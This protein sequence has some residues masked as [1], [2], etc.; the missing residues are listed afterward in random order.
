LDS[1][2]VVNVLTTVPLNLFTAGALSAFY[3][4]NEFKPDI[5]INAGTAGGFKRAG[6]A[7]GDAFI[8]TRCAHHDR[9]IPIP[10][11]TEYGKGDYDSIPCKNLVEVSDYLCCLMICCS[12]HTIRTFSGLPAMLN[13]G[14]A[15]SSFIGDYRLWASSPAY[16]RPPTP[17][18]T[19]TWCGASLIVR[20]SNIYSFHAELWKDSME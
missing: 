14:R 12:L 18:T 10:G 19:A 11:F 2:G 1:A 4:I 15:F 7:I 6:A 8:T 9:R 16:A 5:V 13:Y 20:Y 17:W 3:A